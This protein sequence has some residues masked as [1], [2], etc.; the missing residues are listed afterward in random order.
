M[1]QQRIDS[2]DE[3]Y[4]AYASSVFGYLLHLSGDRALA[5]ELTGETFYRA[6]LSIDGFRGDASVKT[7]LLRIARNLYLRQNQRAQRNTSFDALQEQGV[8]FPGRQH[9]PETAVLHHEQHHALQ[10]A[11]QQLSE[12]DRTLLL[13]VTQ[14]EMPQREVAQILGISLSATK[15]RLFRARQRLAALLETTL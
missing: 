9:D 11:L 15:V 3:L 5:D 12:Q 7:W 14:E 2:L 6:I 4:E 1:R 8:V 10:R 13:L